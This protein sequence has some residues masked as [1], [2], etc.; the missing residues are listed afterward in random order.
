MV[1]LRQGGPRIYRGDTYFCSEDFDLRGPEAE[2]DTG[3][4]PVILMTGG[5]HYACAPKETE[6]TARAVPGVQFVH[7]T[8]IGHF[9]MAENYPMFRTHLLPVLTALSER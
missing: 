5:Y 9:P 4:C 1:D 6:A 3:K 2:I 8:G 7:M